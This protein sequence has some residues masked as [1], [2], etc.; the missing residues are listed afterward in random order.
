MSSSRRNSKKPKTK[1]KAKTKTK[2][3]PK[4]KTKKKSKPRKVVMRRSKRRDTSKWDIPNILDRIKQL[5]DHEPIKARRIKTTGVPTGKDQ[6][7]LKRKRSILMSRI[8]NYELQ[9]CEGSSGESEDEDAKKEQ[10]WKPPPLKHQKQKMP[11]KGSVKRRKGR[12]ISS[13]QTCTNLETM[14]TPSPPATE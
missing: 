12:K 14:R 1:S 10:L 4:K 3:K 7:D 8:D 6:R 9:Y 11:I 2:A 13:M 5:N